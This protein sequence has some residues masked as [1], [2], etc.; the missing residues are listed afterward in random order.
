MPDC[1]QGHG[2]RVAYTGVS[3]GVG[4]HQSSFSRLCFALLALLLITNGASA[5]VSRLRVGDRLP[6]LSGESLNGRA[7][8]LPAAAA[9]A[10]AVVLMGFTYA[11]REPVERWDAWCRGEFGA[12]VACYQMPVLGGMAK[13][14]S[15]F[16][17]SG[18][19]KSTP[20][21]LQDR[22][23]TITSHAGDWKDRVGHTSA[24]DDDAF[25]ILIDRAAIVRWLAHGDADAERTAALKREVAALPV[26]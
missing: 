25:V 16:I 15:P 23:V 9:G 22:V 3:T 7:V 19:R 6:D 11:S 2:H 20:A 12:A 21:P 4:M 17:R 1:P 8:T 18:M 5:D 26:K 24:T 10:P 14:A 13:L